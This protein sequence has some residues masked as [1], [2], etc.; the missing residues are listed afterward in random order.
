MFPKQPWFYKLG[1][2]EYIGMY[3]QGEDVVKAWDPTLYGT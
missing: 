1:E 2:T 3:L